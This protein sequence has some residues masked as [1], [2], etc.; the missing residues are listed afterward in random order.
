MSADDLL[1]PRSGESDLLAHLSGTGSAPTVFA[2]LRPE[3]AEPDWER[4]T[5]EIQASLASDLVALGLALRKLSM[6]GAHRSAPITPYLSAPHTVPSPRIETAIADPPTMYARLANVDLR[7]AQVKRSL[8]MMGAVAAPVRETGPY[9][10]QLSLTAVFGIL[11]G[12]DG[13]GAP[14]PLTFPGGMIYDT[15]GNVRRRRNAARRRKSRARRATRS[16]PAKPGSG[17][18]V[19]EPSSTGAVG[20][21]T[22]PAI[23]AFLK[24]NR[25]E[26]FDLQM[27]NA[28][29]LPTLLEEAHGDPALITAAAQQAEALMVRV[30]QELDDPLKRRSVH[31]GSGSAL[32]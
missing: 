11:R 12:W 5:A 30:K 13:L 10:E 20:P 28:L 19:P 32:A 9:Q 16:V 27:L 21:A 2:R 7:L 31:S 1:E 17:P 6:T 23:T 15:T 18:E 3:G 26:R 4:L 22:G 29:R 24:T 8:T 25:T 14:P